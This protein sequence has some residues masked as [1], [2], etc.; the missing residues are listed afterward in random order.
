[1]ILKTLRRHLQYVSLYYLGV[2]EK[3]TDTPE[4]KVW[5]LLFLTT[6]FP[7]LQID[8]LC[9]AS[10]FISELRTCIWTWSFSYKDPSIQYIR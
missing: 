4:K 3:I 10:N 1:M 6:V 9:S 7:S 2:A 5:F 8:E